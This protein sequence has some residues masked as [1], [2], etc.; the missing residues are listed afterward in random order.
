[1][2]RAEGVEVRL[3]GSD[4]VLP[5]WLERQRDPASPAFVP[6]LARGGSG[7]RGPLNLTHTEAT[8]VGVLG[9]GS[10]AYVDP[11]GLV[12]I[13]GSCWSL[14]WWI[15]A[16]DGWHLPSRSAA[17]RQH[18]VD[19]APVVETRMRI[20]G[21]DAIQRVYA[22]VTAPADGGLEVLVV[23]V[24]NQSAV[25][26]A[27]AF[28]V[29]PFTAEAVGS[30]ERLAL[31]G[32]TLTVG[33]DDVLVLPKPPARWAASD[34]VADSSVAVRDGSACTGTVPEIRCCD[35]FAQAAFVYPLPH[36]I[37]LR[38]IVPLA[39]AEPL[40]GRR[41]PGGR[42]LEVRRRFTVPSSLPSAAQVA[43]G[44]RQHAGSGARVAL[45]PGRLGEM[46]DA[47]R[48]DLLLAA[49]G[50]DISGP[51]VSPA[52]LGATAAVIGALDVF[53]HHD[54]AER[55]LSAIEDRLAL[56]GHLLGS[57][58]RL[59]A[60]GA[61]LVAL[62]R[63]VA[64]TGDVDLAERLAGPI[65]KAAH[66][67][68]KRRRSRRNRRDPATVGLLP[69]GA[70]P[71]WV[72]GLRDD[73]WFRDDFWSLAGLRA[74]ATLL[75][76]AGQPDAAD[77]VEALAANFFSS[78]I[79]ALR[80]ALTSAGGRALPAAPGRPVDS[81]VLT[82]LD[83][84]AEGIDGLFDGTEGTSGDW[85][86]STLEVIRE[87]F[88]GRPGSPAVA[89]ASSGA[90]SSPLLTAMLA[91]AELRRI[92]APGEQRSVER[93]AWL[94][95]HAVSGTGWPETINPRTGGGSRGTSDVLA[96]ATFL[97][98]VREL[99]IA[100]HPDRLALLTV[101]PR[102]WLGHGVEVHGAPTR[103]GRLSYAVRWH[104]ERP[105]LLWELEPAGDAGL[106]GALA[107]P[108]IVVPGLDPAWSTNEPRGETLLAPP[109]ATLVDFR[110]GSG[111]T[112][113]SSS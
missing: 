62:E 8:T 69:D 10:R 105:A 68:D 38:V 102:D 64:L 75:R 34:G 25:P 24:E 17:V 50:D 93:L 81:S 18:L 63:H 16:E 70:A 92:H 76:G 45:P 84:L 6:A 96:G 91:R 46:V 61:V 49:T 54:P 94:A 65:A 107:C 43:K 86:G 48:C 99:L 27:V 29:R 13:H 90:G 2:D 103:F 77:Q 87:R 28:A 55:V 51:G 9:H 37:S 36:T 106:P 59:D 21:G 89:E 1:V 42:H 33:D 4:W 67:V 52:D 5:F 79:G 97:R 22:T 19:N 98:A 11:R 71:R 101:F 56:D 14:D 111:E 57:E 104:G 53:G 15:G 47:C 109:P 73:C 60:N 7:T 74:A 110:T 112:G 35:G 78:L 40:V 82:L 113:E 58:R 32:T 26:V 100:E 3:G 23:E 72:P 95:A 83:V 108:T 80:G 20:P 41:R 85:G 44:W 12:T 88:V 31:D 30:I 66:W 39:P